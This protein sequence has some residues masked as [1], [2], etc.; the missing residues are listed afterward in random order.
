MA[1]GV[2]TEVWLEG[3]VP[4]V[5]P[6]LQPVAHALL[7]ARREVPT[8]LEKFPEDKIWERPAGLACVAFHLQH[9]AGVQ[10]RLFTYARG[11]AL[12]SDQLKAL[13]S[14]GKPRDDL[15]LSVL[16]ERFDAQVG[17]SIRQLEGT[18]PKTLL[19][20]RTVGRKQVP[21]T[22]F[23]LLVHAAEHTQRH[24]GQL[25]VTSAV[26]QYEIKTDL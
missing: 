24:L 8:L 10:D 7:Q 22:L 18:S 19:D 11:E 16:L 1:S 25:L 12:S 15:T 21:S 6:L 14:E 23:G 3:A 2:S 5:D 17:T 26:L 4:G 9:M 20:S 13:A